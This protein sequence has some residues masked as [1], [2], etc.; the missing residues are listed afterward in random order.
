MRK[1]YFM[2]FAMVMMLA[3][4]TKPVETRDETKQEEEII[5]TEES[6]EEQS[7]NAEKV[8]STYLYYRTDNFVTLVFEDGTTEE[9]PLQCENIE[10]I[11]LLTED[12]GDIY[13]STMTYEENG[14]SL[15]NL[16]KIEYQNKELTEVSSLEIEDGTYYSDMEIKDGD[17]YLMACVYLDEGMR[18]KQLVLEQQDNGDYQQ[19]N[20]TTSIYDTI[21][22]NGYELI[23]AIKSGENSNYYSVPYCLNHFGKIIV[24]K[25][26]TSDILLLN[27]DGSVF[28]T[29]TLSGENQEICAT[30]GKN[31]I[32]RIQDEENWKLLSCNLETGEEVTITEQKTDVYWYLLDYADNYLYYDMTTTVNLGITQYQL[33]CVNDQTGA[34]KLLYETE[35]VPGMGW[36][37]MPGISGFKV[38]KDFCYYLAVDGNDISWFQMNLEDE[39]LQQ[40][41]LQ[42]VSKHFESLDNGTITYHAED[43]VCPECNVVI[44]QEYVEN[45]LIN[46]SYPNAALINE[47]LNT[48]YQ[49]EIAA[50][51]EDILD[52][53]HEWHKDEYFQAS[54]YELQLESAEELGTHY[55]QVNY[56]AYYYMGGAHGEQALIH[57]LFDLDTGKEVTIADLY[58]GT[59]EE[60]KTLVAEYTREYYKENSYS[61]FAS[62]E[63][64]AYEQAYESAS[65]EM[66]LRFTD[67]VLEVEY[68]P[69]CLGPYAVGYITVEI[70]YE[71]L[72][73][74]I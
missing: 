35:T 74:T 67:A 20:D 63:E 24:R 19:V 7:D 48:Y 51:Q 13:Y 68:P 9:V 46:D 70:P 50:E 6:T 21:C 40:Q 59:E 18:Y 1:I 44:N 17:I 12:Q 41:S 10:D 53:D 72:G 57:Y 30:D 39:S 29:I 54:T 71:I 33:W 31:I 25:T 22:D 64:E 61:F 32:Y 65:F 26:D 11:N 52:G 8:I 43:T 14:R 16:Y 58:S 4:C 66:T 60:F 23:Y 45:Y 36:D 34:T 28:Q 55:F 27:E 69:Y 5:Q 37:Y 42:V 15:F 38:N 73:I 49:N 2:F 62:N 3:G 56:L 47:Q